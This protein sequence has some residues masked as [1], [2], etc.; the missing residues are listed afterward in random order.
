[1]CDGLI[2]IGVF[3]DIENIS[4]PKKKSA[5]RIVQTI[6]HT[7]F[8]GHKEAEF[9]CVCDTVKERKDVIQELNAAQVTVIHV[10]ATS[11][12]AADDKLRQSLRRFADVYSS[13]AT[14]LL[15]SSD[16]NFSSDLSDLRHRK[17]LNVILIHNKEVHKS[18]TACANRTVL[19]DDL[20]SKM[21]QC[22]KSVDLKD[23]PTDLEIRGYGPNIRKK[24]LQN[25]FKQ[26]STNCGGKVICV[27]EDVSVVRFQS[28]TDAN[29]ARNRMEGENVFGNKIKVEI[30]SRSPQK[31]DKQ[32]GN[33][34]FK[35]PKD[36][37][38]QS[39][40]QTWT[41]TNQQNNAKPGS[42]VPNDPKQES[43]TN[44][45]PQNKSPPGK[46]LYTRNLTPTTS[47]N[48]KSNS[49][50]TPTPPGSYTRNPYYQSFYNNPASMYAKTLESFS[51]KPFSSNRNNIENKNLDQQKSNTPAIQILTNNNRQRKTSE[52]ENNNSASLKL[53]K[54][55]S[56]VTQKNISPVAQKSISPIAQ[57]NIIP[58][59]QKNIIPIAQKNNS[60]TVKKKYES[61]TS[62]GSTSPTLQKN[63]SPN[64]MRGPVQ[65]I[66]N[67]NRQ[68]TSHLYNEKKPGD[69][70][71]SGNIPYKGSNQDNY[72]PPNSGYQNDQPQNDADNRSNLHDT[73]NKFNKDGKGS[74]R[75]V[76][77]LQQQL[78]QED[79]QQQDYHG[80]KQYNYHGHSYSPPP[81]PTPWS[82]YDYHEPQHDMTF[83]SSY[84]TYQHF[85]G[86][87]YDYRPF[88]YSQ[89]NTYNNN[90]YGCY[91][92]NS[93]NQY[94]SNPYRNQRPGTS[95]PAPNCQ[96]MCSTVVQ[97]KWSHRCSPYDMVEEGP[98]MQRQ[99]PMNMFRPITPSPVPG[100]CS[101]PA[102]D[103]E[104]LEWEGF[105]G[106]VELLVSNLDYNIS[107]KEWRKILFTTFH[108]HVRVLNVHVKTQPDNTSIGMVKVPNIEEARFAISQFHRKKIGYKRIHVT[109]KQEETQRPAS[110]T[111][112]EAIALLSEA[113]D[114]FLPL[115]KFI[116]L[117][118]KRYHRTISVSELY[119]MRDTLEIRELSG[120]RMVHLVCN[121]PYHS[122]P[123]IIT[124]PEQDMY[125]QHNMLSM[126]Q[127]PEVLEQPAC[128]IHCPEGSIM[129]A[130]AVNNC[131]LPNVM[132]TIKMFGP[133]VHS[134]LQSHDGNMPLMSFAICFSAEF[135]CLPI[136][137]DS[138]IPL[139]HLIS[140]VQGIQIQV[141]PSG[142]KKVQWAENKP[143][144]PPD[145]P[146]GGSNPLLSQQ[147]NQFS[148]EMIEL[149]KSCPKC[150]MPF[151]K[152]IP[153][154]HHFFNKQ[155]RVADYGYTRLKDLFDAVPHVLQVLGTGERK[156]LTLSHRAQIKRF[157]ADLQK[158][159]KAQ[160]GKQ[161]KLSS[162]TDN[163]TLV[164]N[165]DFDA[166]DYGMACVEDLL[167]DVSPISVIVL[168]EDTDTII[169]IPRKDQTP[170]EIERTK[171]FSLEVVDLLKHNPQCRMPFNKFI[172][173]FHHHFGRQCRVS[174]YGF[175][176]LLDLFEAIPHIVDIEE[177]GEE[178]LIHLTESELRKVLADQIVELLKAQK[179]HCLA[180]HHLMSAF[181]CHFGFNIPLHDFYVNSEEELVQKLKHVVRIDMIN[182]CKYIRLLDRQ[183]TPEL[184]R[185]VLQ[186]LMDQ[187]SGSLPLMELLSRYKSIFGK[188]CD[189]RQLKDELL[190]YV[191]IK[192]DD[193]SGIISLTSLQVLARDVRVL[194]QNGLQVYVSDFDR[195]YKDQFGVDLKPAL[196]GYTSVETLLEAIPHVVQFQGK[197]PRRYVELS[198]DLDGNTLS[199]PD[200]KSI[201]PLLL[202]SN[203]P[204]NESERIKKLLPSRVDLLNEPVPSS[205]PS[206][207]LHPKEQS[208]RDLISFDLSTYSD[209]ADQLWRLS[210]E[211]KTGQKTPLCMTPTSELLQLAAKCL[212]S[213][214]PDVKNDTQKS[215]SIT[216][217]IKNGWWKI[218]KSQETQDNS[219]ETVTPKQ[220]TTI[221]STDTIGKS[222]FEQIFNRSTTDVQKDITK[223]EATR[224]SDYRRKTMIHSPLQD[225]LLSHDELA[226][227]KLKQVGI[228]MESQTK[229]ECVSKDSIS[230]ETMFRRDFPIETSSIKS[231]TST[232]SDVS[233]DSPKKSPRKPRLA[234][235][236][237]IPIDGS[238]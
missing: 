25:R 232:L 67:D 49:N 165:K 231:D 217:I 197:T 237:D 134:L 76:L 95:P 216:D 50:R 114:N 42:N 236:F 161:L 53:E 189:I 121:S 6:R 227:T 220:E 130:E 128:P 10:N 24:R 193:E 64:A 187:S 75:H 19:Y 93:W 146:T 162:F 235:K 159:V 96:T 181:T 35:R 230:Y 191:Q 29:R 1:M 132:M 40:S 175:T 102:M 33:K 206:P 208:P 154:Y 152:F 183:G 111:R 77:M 143:L 210:E 26:L 221:K 94:N 52:K 142:V 215:E 103:D 218:V 179:N 47:G 32:Q 155:C 198:H 84:P 71:V 226:L 184:A 46:S 203:S 207:D 190:D 150:R 80:R 163:Y 212:V 147:L 23:E 88:S 166:L 116:E 2:P 124:N 233:Q 157:T 11:K 224:S 101:S 78:Y 156:V 60:P 120:T 56:P 13:P 164:M 119:K 5:F 136:V 148:K 68:A 223:E 34:G 7:F 79:Q 104:D 85:G 16:V 192:G 160:Y 39:Q 92:N 153:S 100:A 131:M 205:V 135:G 3:W 38:S 151:T 177:D 90:P 70:G 196:F 86:N 172:P 129:Y 107:A 201:S 97:Q 8:N 211:E 200:P 63:T 219:S 48:G 55:I 99:S 234:A 144:S 59:A 14:V 122:E 65:N 45:L 51:S 185:Q 123:T 12:N 43:K 204:T 36:T 138:G 125:Y 105:V 44:S 174:D 91:R 4:I 222:L 137:G 170:E 209:L 171:E 83:D 176:K 141:S 140:C 169:A 9:V 37:S 112:A 186:L 74:S 195:V 109:L 194:L 58:T 18:L 106:P 73:V 117:F 62:H 57:K 61:P 30:S 180:L 115:F 21:Q 15:L 214:P 229:K 145:S 20:T 69:N 225:T 108:P 149:L 188:E 89:N 72:I 213:R 113:K 167:N 110:S 182:R 238:H 126:N 202:L 118:D 27:K 158:I 66:T 199:S 81:Y 28:Y 17:N 54:N 168:Q 31:T 173:S 228:D 82:T 87:N 139:E 133:Q 22:E 41:D 98:A 178:R 127:V